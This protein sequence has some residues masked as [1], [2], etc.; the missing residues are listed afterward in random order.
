VTDIIRIDGVEYELNGKHFYAN[1]CVNVQL[2]PKRKQ[3]DI[4]YALEEVR[5][6]LF[7]L[8]SAEKVLRKVVE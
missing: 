8:E 2:R 1:G 7:A 5:G 3:T 6:A 4:A